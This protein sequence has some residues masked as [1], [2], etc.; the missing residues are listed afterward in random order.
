VGVLESVCRSEKGLMSQ[1]ENCEDALLRVQDVVHE[2]RPVG[3]GPIL[4]ALAGV[5]FA[6]RK[7]ETLGIV[8]E[9]GSG[10]T[11]LARAL[12]QA[13]A[14][15][16]GAVYFRGTDLT[17]LRGRD[18]L[19][20]R[21][22]MQLVFQDPFGSL[23]PK[24]QVADIVAEPLVGYGVGDRRQRRRKV[25]EVLELVGLPAPLY[26]NRRPRE[27]SGGQCQRVAIARA[28]TLDPALIICDEAVSALDVLVQA[29]LLNVL[30]TLRTELSLSYI[31]ISHDLALVRQI[32]DRIAV[33]HLGQLC[34]IGATEE[35]YGHPKH[36][37]SAALI[38]SFDES[39]LDAAALEVAEAV[40][41]E[42]PSPFDPPSG[43]RFRTRCPR[44]MPRCAMGQ[45]L[46]LQVGDDHVVA[47]HFRL[48]AAHRRHT[49][50][51]REIC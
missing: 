49:Q 33:M 34:E 10:K 17:R 46:L 22:H 30:E 2:F 43:C 39:Q 47:C 6:V 5:S 26:G 21:R 37:Y 15:D 12:L 29:Q 45:P 25:E 41:S 28:L 19:E 3:N 31:F 27:L 38:A 36:P 11:T 4:R 40:T 50:V 18:L 14:P 23:N 13:P 20:H 1:N 8:G 32:S 42:P 51:A 44:A 16:S 48:D 9:S 35:V 24:W 7:G